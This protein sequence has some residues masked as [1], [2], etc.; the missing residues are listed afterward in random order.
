MVEEGGWEASGGIGR[1]REEEWYSQGGVVGCRE[2]K[3]RGEGA[4]ESRLDDDLDLLKCAGTV[5]DMC[6]T[7][8][9]EKDLVLKRLS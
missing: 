6:Q 2:R 7:I 5:S 9:N 1:Y 8:K 3:G 4:I